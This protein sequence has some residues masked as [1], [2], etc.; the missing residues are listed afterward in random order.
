MP[1]KHTFW[2]TQMSPQGCMRVHTWE[3][4]RAVSLP[5]AG[6][7]AVAPFGVPGP[8]ALELGAWPV[9]GGNLGVVGPGAS[10]GL[11]VGE[12]LPDGD[13]GGGSTAASSMR[14]WGRPSS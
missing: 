3:D 7:V 5:P 11:E 12:A 13:V 9:P 4:F 6:G 14:L 2:Y 1:L 10:M 8:A